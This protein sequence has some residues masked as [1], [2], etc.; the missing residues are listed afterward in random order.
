MDVRRLAREWRWM[1]MA[2][3]FGMLAACGPQV[4]EE[5]LVAGEALTE[6]GSSSKVSALAP[7]PYANLVVQSGV[8]AVI[9]PGNAVGAPDGNVASFLGLLGG[10]LLLDMGEGEAG[11]G[12]LRIYY[13]GLSL[14][15]IAQVDFLRE[16]LSLISTGQAALVDL[17]IGTHSA[18]VPFSSATPYRYVRLRGGLAALY[19]VDAVEDMGFGGGVFCGNGQVDTE[20]QCDDGNL[21]SGDGCGAGCQVAPGYSC[22][23]TQ[24][25]VCTDVNECTNGTSQ[26]SVNATCTNTPGS[27]NCTCKPGY[28]GNGWTC[29]DI[30]ECA[31]GTAVCQVGELCVNTPGAYTCV[32]GAC[33]SPTV[34]C[35]SQ[36]VDVSS[37]ASNCGACG[38]VCDAGQTC[39]ESACVADGIK[40][41]IATSWA[42]A[43]DG[44][45]VVRTPSGKLIYGGNR[46]PGIETDY[47]TLDRIASAGW[48]PERV[49]WNA[50]A[51]PPAGQYDVCFKAAGFSPPPSAENPVS[52][53]VTVRWLG[54]PDLIVWSAATSADLGAECSPEHP[55][56]VVSFTY[57]GGP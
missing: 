45:L 52:Y 51:P 35:G 3:A 23:G 49:I 17:G 54:R 10:S 8:I 13:R 7:D 27:Y 24:P 15:V 31:N 21:V 32:A 12:P 50:G 28:S 16:D 42:R 19:S 56:H 40:L 46:G 36:C 4:E 43:G 22:S 6:V 41:Q 37:D 5:S 33:Q 34:Q 20:E 55:T 1:R 14:S 44:D 30:D 38:N 9:N 39:L 2:L 11:T 48:G 53:T 26:C 18:L 47:G 57:P 29:D 25:S